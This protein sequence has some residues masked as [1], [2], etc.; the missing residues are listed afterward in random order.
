M[1]DT[2]VVTAVDHKPKSTKHLKRLAN[3]RSYPEVTLLVQNYSDDD[4]DSLWWV[5]IRGRARVVETGDDRELALDM[6]CDKY[7]QYKDERPQGAVVIVE[8]LAVSGW[9]ASS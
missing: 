6:L 9:S 1:N 5:R 2:T 3:I 7:E 4:W 8:V